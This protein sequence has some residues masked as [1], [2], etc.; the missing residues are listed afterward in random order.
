MGG[1]DVK[2][3]WKFHLLNTVQEFTDILVLDP[4]LVGDGCTRL[5]DVLDIVTRDDELV[6]DVGEFDGDTGEHWA[7]SDDLFAHCGCKVGVAGVV[8]EEGEG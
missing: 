7:F 6:L 3:I 4:R 5:R 2:N 8:N 1:Y